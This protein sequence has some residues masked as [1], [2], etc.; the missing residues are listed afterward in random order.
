MRLLNTESLELSRPYVPNEVPDYAILSHRWNTEEITF[1]DLSNA[2]ILHPQSKVRMKNGFAKIQGACKLA[3]NDGYAWIWIDSCCIDKSSSA[4]LQEAINSMWRYYAESNICYVYLADVSDSEAG[5]GPM[6][7]KSEWFTRGWT[8]Q[9]LIAPT[10]VEFFAQNWAAIGTKFE[11]YI[12]IAEITSIDPDA[13]MRVQD[14]DLFST[15]ERLSW[16]SHRNVTREEDEAY[17]LLGLFDINMPLLYGEGREQAFVRFQKAIYNATADHSIFF[18]RHGQHKDAQPLLASSPASFCDRLDCS[19]CLSRGSQNIYSNFRYRNILA[20]ERWSEQAH[21]HIMTTVTPF[22]NEMSTVL[23]LLAYR[24]VSCKLEFFDKETPRFRVTHVAVLNH[25]LE[26]YPRGAFCLLLRRQPELDACLSLQV[27]PAVLPD[28]GDLE[29]RIQKTKL[30]ICPGPCDLESENRM[31]TVFTVAS[32]LFHIEARGAKGTNSRTLLS[33]Q[34]GQ[35]PEFKVQIRKSDTSKS[36]VQVTCHVSGS[37][38]PKLLLT[39][40]LFRMHGLWSVKEIVE[41]KKGKKERKLRRLFISTILA[42]RCAFQLQDGEMLSVKLRRLPSSART[43]GGY[44]VRNRYQILID[45][46]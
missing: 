22:R 23:P 26:K 12:Q 35:N 30:L 11:R 43:P 32:D 16:A 40:R 6:F 19:H 45:R 25:T 15:A 9:E 46:R 2:P 18:F 1:A 27:L 17:A 36:L 39:I 13:L 3:R 41:T 10:S 33:A 21:E 42:D 29:S 14:I 34:T 37:Q 20:S 44:V 28:L 8:L 31:E 38:N 24:D 7:A 4:E 5:W